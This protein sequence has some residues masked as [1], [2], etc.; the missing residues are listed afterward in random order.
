[1]AANRQGTQSS[2][3]FLF[4]QYAQHYDRWFE[5]APGRLQFPG[6]L[7][8]LRMVLRE[9]PRPW[10][11]VGVGTG[12]FGA[13]LGVDVGVDPSRPMLQRARARKLSGV[14][15]TAEELPF[16]G[17]G[18]GAVLLVTTL[19][20]V[21]DPTPLLQEAKRVLQ[22]EGALVVADVLKESTW[23]SRYQ[24]QGAE[25]HPLYRHMRLYT[26]PEIEDLLWA[27]GFQVTDR[28]CSLVQPPGKVRVEER[29]WWG[30]SPRASFAAARARLR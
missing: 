19:C 20:F 26:L 27:A 10:L 25:G 2:S 8:A 24:E 15:G 16:R 11:E 18:F 6:E 13:A 7:E 12:R 29:A 17:E 1:M 22:A 28:A 4:D 3:P 9:P 21:L 23:G 30:I 14:Q 5:R